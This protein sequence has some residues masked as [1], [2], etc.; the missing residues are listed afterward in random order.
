MPQSPTDDSTTA[1]NIIDGRSPLELQPGHGLILVEEGTVNLFVELLAGDG[2]QTGARLCVATLEAGEGVPLPEDAGDDFRIVA[3]G[4][5]RARVTVLD[6]P[7]RGGLP[8]E[9]DR[10]LGAL[11]DAA[12]SG[13]R[14]AG[15]NV[16]P[17][18]DEPVEN[19]RVLTASVVVW[20]ELRDA[21]GEGILHPV[22]PARSLA[23]GAGTRVVVRSTADTV[24]EKGW[25]ALDPWVDVLYRD[26]A[27]RLVTM[28]R[29]SEERARERGAR[30]R[31]VVS[32][33]L[34]EL[35]ALMEGRTRVATHAAAE[36]HAPPLAAL[37]VLCRAEGI[38]I[39][40][41]AAPPDT[42]D[43][44]QDL[45]QV[46]RRASVRS[47]RIAL[48]MTWWR[49]DVTS[50]IGFDGESGGARPVIRRAPGHFELVDPENGSRRRV[51]AR[52]AALLTRHALVVYR[53]L[54]HRVLRAMDLVRHVLASPAR[55]D[56]R[57]AAVMAM[58]A[59]LLGL[60]TPIITGVI[61]NEAVPFGEMTR[62]THLALGLVMVA[63]GSALFQFV[64]AVALL[65]IESFTDSG[66]Q[67]AVWDRLL[68]LPL[69][70][71]RRYQVGELMIKAMAPTQLRQALSDTVVGSALGAV[72]SLVNFGLML[73]YS[74]TLAF[75]ALGFTLLSGLLLF[76]LTWRQLRYERTLL[77]ADGKVSGLILQLLYGIEKIRLA[78]AE[79]RA[80][81]R[82]LAGFSEQRLQ[83]F[84]AATIGN[85]IAT[86]NAV[87]PLLASLLFFV[88]MGFAIGS[89]PVGDFV[90][91]T[92]AFG[93]FQA[94]ML[95]LVGA[96]SISLGAIPLYENM[97]AILEE[98]P[99]IGPERKD[100]G[101]LNGRI[102]LHD[103][104]FRYAEDGPQ[105]L[106]N[107]DIVI[108][109][110]EF[111]ALVGPSGSGKSTVFR[112][113]LGFEVPETG[114]VSYDDR[115]LAHLDLQAVRRQL[116]VVLQ[117]GTVLP[118]SV[119]E[120]IVGSTALGEDE[121]WEA[122]RIAGLDE[123]IQRMP[124]G[125][126]TVLSEGGGA[127]S[128]GQRQRLMIA[129]AVVRRP[130]MLLMDEATSAL[131]NRTQALVAA[132]LERM[133]A[134]RV[135]IA[136]RLSTVRHADRIYVIDAGRVVQVGTF[137][138]LMATPGVF[139]QIAQRQMA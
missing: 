107:V 10:P 17:G 104:C 43:A 57:W 31:T 91:F 129:R 124:M 12:A 98:Q 26:I 21:E 83:R 88:V 80:Y 86:L 18:Q 45:Q 27:G 22:S 29:E 110:G 115:D 128:G 20:I 65:R 63:V 101:P 71:F 59:A 84:R 52:E 95:G 85:V 56:L 67:A 90:A 136:H 42:G 87:L 132:S 102:G 6:R 99:E 16:R 123:D 127:I 61:I 54:P 38:V 9:L 122:A 53:P 3:I 100:P 4:V 134:T 11:F 2:R 106:Q 79:N 5:G 111:V 82:W 37:A 135:V 64:R 35:P 7:D 109:P 77:Q 50:F 131:D 118:G 48:P 108:E 36:A 68:R 58:L 19:D 113:L 93:Q 24:R 32:G 76:G 55:I 73:F 125:M 49:G 39:D 133:N 130:R 103:V 114:T 96:M 137:E 75:A 138:E 23:V 74:T 72:F 28:L 120:N 15:W 33:M 126:H 112:L 40:L 30:D 1:T 34:A 44:E 66:L 97:K 121:A 116:G 92:V 13:A 8:A 14:P 60:L 89:I 47:R 51:G 119:L 69:T 139:Q 25:N 81:V 70:F 62:L 105:I 41:P 117:R 46:L 78:G 94:A